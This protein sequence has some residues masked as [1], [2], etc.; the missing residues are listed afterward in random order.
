MKRFL[1]SLAMFSCAGIVNAQPPLANSRT[2]IYIV[3]HG[4]KELGND[5]ALTAAGKVRAGD[6]MR[7]LKRKDIRHIYVSQ[8]RRTQMTGD[9][10][11]IQLGIDTIR[12][13]A[14]TTGVDLLN[15]IIA[16]GDQRRAI[17]VIGHSNTIPQ[18][19]RKL[20][21]MN[22][23]QENIADNEFDNLF[24]VRYKKHKARVTKY[25]YGA[26]TGTSAG[27]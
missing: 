16:N 15:K 3:R 22:Y 6:L 26:A 2:R 9:S 1:L 7:I 20:G 12:Y 18:I 17:L 23:P 13:K 14:D 8:Y 4:E 25:K 19:I 27:M 5:P 11:R 10:M 21:V 24:L